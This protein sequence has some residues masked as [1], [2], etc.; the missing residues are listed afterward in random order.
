MTLPVCAS[1][2]Y[3]HLPHTM[4]SFWEGTGR[5]SP[6]RVSEVH[7]MRLLVAAAAGFFLIPGIA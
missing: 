3:G 6:P 7:I 2:Q 5:I 1:Y 4:E